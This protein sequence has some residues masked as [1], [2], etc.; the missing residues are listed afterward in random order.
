[1]T[2]DALTTA[3]LERGLV[4]MIR[5]AEPFEPPLKGGIHDR[6][7]PRK[8]VYPY[9][10][11]SLVSAPIV[12]DDGVTVV[13]DALYDI[14]VVALRSVDA[15]NIDLQLARLFGGRY[16]DRV[17]QP[18]VEG[19]HVQVCKRVSAM[20]TGPERS[21]TGTRVVQIGSTYNIVVDAPVTDSAPSP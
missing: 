6:L 13:I 19:Q 15:K 9:L 8:L 3:P 1:M 14:S 5:S 17:L 2:D 12:A 10:L 16:A 21:G 20:P 4:R 18:F 7:S 11:Y